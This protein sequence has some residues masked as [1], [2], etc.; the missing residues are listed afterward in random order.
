MLKTAIILE[1]Y[2]EFPTVG[3]GDSFLLLLI[4]QMHVNFGN[5]FDALKT[6]VRQ[7]VRFDAAE[8]S[9]VVHFVDQFLFFGTG[10]CK[11]RFC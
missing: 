7:H 9:V 2:F 1:T 3:D 10:W 4:G 6:H 5:G 8:E 11:K